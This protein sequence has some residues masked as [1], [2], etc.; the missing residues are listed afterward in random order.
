MAPLPQNNTGRAWLDYVTGSG[1]SAQQH[2]VMLRFTG[3][4][5]ADGT[6]AL[7]ALAALIVAATEGAFFDGWQVVGARISAP[8]SDFALPA[9]VPAVLTS[10]LGEG[11]ANPTYQSQAREARLVGRGTSTGRR[12]SVSLYGLVDSLF[13]SADFRL[14]AGG[15]GFVFNLLEA[16]NEAPE[17]VAVSIGGDSV[18]WQ[19]YMNWQYNS[20][21]EGALRS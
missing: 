5:E 1:F 10:F 19:S 20:Y 12:V 6:A 13:T 4:G 17:G 3:E 15:S 21:W 18:T 8:G 9:A 11:Q 16:L 7:A 2:S 14:P